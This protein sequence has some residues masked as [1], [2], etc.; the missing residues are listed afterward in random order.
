[1]SY[2]NAAS[3]FNFWAGVVVF[4]MGTALEI[5]MLFVSS[6]PS[7]YGLVFGLHLMALGVLLV[8]GRIRE[9]MENRKRVGS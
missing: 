9:F 2:K 3:W 4:L 7:E 6:E 1:M 5:K 8:H